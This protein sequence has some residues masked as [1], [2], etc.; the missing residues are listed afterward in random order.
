MALAPDDVLFIEPA[1]ASSLIDKIKIGDYY[2]NNVIAEVSLDNNYSLLGIEF[3]SK[4]SNVE[5]NM[6]EQVLKLYK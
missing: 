6:K 5:W 1:T 2:L 4:F 3:L